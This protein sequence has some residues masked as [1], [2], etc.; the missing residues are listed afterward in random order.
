MS[1]CPRGSRWPAR[2]TLFDAVMM[3]SPVSRHG[4]ENGLVWG[5]CIVWVVCCTADAAKPARGGRGKARASGGEGNNRAPA[6]HPP[7][8]PSQQSLR[9]HRSFLLAACLP[10][11]PAPLIDSLLSVRSAAVVV[12]DHHYSSSSSSSPPPVL[13]ARRCSGA[14]GSES[15]SASTH[16]DHAPSISFP[17]S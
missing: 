6:R 9:G 15:G 17:T 10:C 4:G 14:Q 7:S 5:V 11:A 16:R 8:A 13:I 2:D 12:V 1:P 3:L